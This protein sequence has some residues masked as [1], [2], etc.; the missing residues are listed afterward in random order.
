MLFLS[1]CPLLTLFFPPARALGEAARPSPAAGDPRV[2]FVWPRCQFT[3]L[4]FP[5]SI[6]A[7]TA[8][9]ISYGGAERRGGM[10]R[11]A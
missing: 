5:I 10:G 3:E 6:T 2:T 9:Q 1:F 11:E 7:G 8:L 4:P